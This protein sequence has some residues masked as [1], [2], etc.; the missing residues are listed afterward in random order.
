MFVDGCLSV[1]AEG[2]VV[3]RPRLVEP[4]EADGVFTLAGQR[5]VP[6]IVPVDGLTEVAPEAVAE[7][8]V[9]VYRPLPMVPGRV[10]GVLP[11]IVP[12]PLPGR[13]EP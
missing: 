5:F 12:A 11:V 6:E 8:P 3:T 2:V 7:L 4:D 1:V 13:S 10:V 9:L